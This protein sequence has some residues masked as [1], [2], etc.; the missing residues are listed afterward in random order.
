MYLVRGARNAEPLTAGSQKRLTASLS[1][2]SKFDALARINALGAPMPIA[3]G[4]SYSGVGIKTAT[5]PAPGLTL[6]NETEHPDVR[7][8]CNSRLSTEIFKG[9]V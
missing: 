7:I 9:G 1:K 6:S 4:V 5:T 3:S 8:T 2:A